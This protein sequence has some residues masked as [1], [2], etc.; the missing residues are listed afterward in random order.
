MGLIL[1]IYFCCPLETLIKAS[2]MTGNISVWDN[3]IKLQYGS[4]KNPNHTKFTKAPPF[5]LLPLFFPSIVFPDVS[6]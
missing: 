1:E 4:D 3:S 6:G 5:I 2:N